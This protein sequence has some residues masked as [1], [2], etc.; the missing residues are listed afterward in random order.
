MSRRVR[1]RAAALWV[2]AQAAA[3]DAAGGKLPLLC[4]AWVQAV[5]GPLQGRDGPV[6]TVR[7]SAARIGAAGPGIRGALV[8][9]GEV[10][11]DDVEAGTA[12]GVNLS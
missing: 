6:Q 1:V 5:L 9:V 3:I 10:G 11:E 2:R 4:P 8:K 12:L 7:S